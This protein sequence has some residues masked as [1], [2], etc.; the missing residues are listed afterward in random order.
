MWVFVGGIKCFVQSAAQK[1]SAYNDVKLRKQAN[2]PI[3]EAANWELLLLKLASW[4]IRYQKPRC[5]A[6]TQCTL[7]IASFKFY[8]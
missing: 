6:Y 7:C 2:P 3:G 1:Y 5:S 4:F 8:K